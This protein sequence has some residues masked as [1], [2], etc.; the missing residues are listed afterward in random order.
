M[1]CFVG[2]HR[3]DPGYLR[4]VFS[5]DVDRTVVALIDIPGDTFMSRCPSL[6]G[7]KVRRVAQ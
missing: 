5:V 1:L 7:S 4:L 2:A 6:F 3:K